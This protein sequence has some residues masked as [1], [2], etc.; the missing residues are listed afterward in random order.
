MFLY[1]YGFCDL[2]WLSF[3]TDIY[4]ADVDLPGLPF[5]CQRPY[6]DDFI[7]QP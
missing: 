2:L 4:G 3:I 6:Q 1:T 7:S 5:C